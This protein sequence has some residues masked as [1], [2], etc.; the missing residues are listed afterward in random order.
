MLNSEQYGFQKRM[1]ALNALS[2]LR[3]TIWA[4]ISKSEELFCTFLDLSKA[5][6]TVNHGILL[7]KL[8]AYRAR[9]I[10][11]QLL[12]SFLQNRKQFTQIDEKVS[13]IRDINV[14]VPQR[15]LFGPLLFLIYINGMTD[16]Q[17]ETSQIFLFADDCSILTS[18]QYDCF[19]AHEKQLHQN[20][21]W[22]GANK[23]T[24]NLEKTFYI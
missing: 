15:C 12:A 22:L 11:F 4:E 21:K 14:A 5:F 17:D 1:S 24:I 19:P 13:E 3:E 16:T 9:G 23:R 2:D 6:D 7:E 20:S 8:E 10:V 18:H